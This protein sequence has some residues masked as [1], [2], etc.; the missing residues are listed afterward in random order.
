[1][2]QMDVSASAA[3]TVAWVV[4]VD[5]GSNP[6]TLGTSSLTPPGTTSTGSGSRVAS[7]GPATSRALDPAL[8]AASFVLSRSVA[9][10][11][12]A[13]QAASL[14][15]IRIIKAAP[16]LSALTGVGAAS[17]T[18]RLWLSSEQTCQNKERDDH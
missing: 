11:Y 7:P 12:L 9:A 16:D 17:S 14:A 18:L 13:T 3:S 6:P 15:G 4:A 5:P 2:S 8:T 10:W 1:V